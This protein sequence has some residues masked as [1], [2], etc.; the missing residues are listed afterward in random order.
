MLFQDIISNDLYYTV[1]WGIL[2]DISFPVIGTVG[3]QT[4]RIKKPFHITNVSTL[5][6]IPCE[7]HCGTMQ[8]CLNDGTYCAISCFLGTFDKAGVEHLLKVHKIKELARNVKNEKKWLNQCVQAPHKSCA[9]LSRFETFE[10]I[11]F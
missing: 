4:L 6:T 1:N 5:S 3:T 2:A 9:P 11:N 10:R 7:D 8:D